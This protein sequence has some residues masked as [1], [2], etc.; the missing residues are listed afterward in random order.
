M[1]YPPSK[2]HSRLFDLLKENV[3]EFVEEKEGKRSTLRK[4]RKTLEK[5]RGVHCLLQPQMNQ[6]K[7]VVDV[8][9]F[10]YS[11]LIPR[12]EIKNMSYAKKI[13]I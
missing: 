5:K 11:E 10:S 1:T 4:I 13:K 2:T 3:D 12:L 7:K 9:E 6:G 8:L